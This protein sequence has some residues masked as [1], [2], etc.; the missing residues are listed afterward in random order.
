[1][2]NEDLAWSLM[3]PARVLYVEGN[4]DGTVGGS[5]FSLLFLLEQ[6][7][8][9]T[10][11]DI[12]RECQAKLEAFMVPKYVDIVPD[13]PKTTTGKIKKTDLK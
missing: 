7:S 8:T 10:V 3:A 12:Q 4:Y 2:W 9:L 13:L 5:Y 1:M 11:K 6:D